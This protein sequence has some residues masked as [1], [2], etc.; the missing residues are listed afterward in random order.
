MS[1]RRPWARSAKRSR[2]RAWS[3]SSACPEIRSCCTTT[4]STGRSG[5]SSSGTRPRPSSWR[6]P[7]RGSPGGSASSTR[8]PAREWRTSSRPARGLYACSPLVSLV[9]AA[10]RNYEG[11][12]VF[13]ETPSLDLARPVTKWA[14]RLDLPTGRRGRSSGRS[15]LAERQAGARFRRD[16]GR[17]RQQAEIPDYRPLA[18]LRGAGDPALVDG[19][20]A[21]RRRRRPVIVVGGGVGL[22]RAEGELVE[23]AERLDA[24]VVTTPSGRGSI[25]ETHRLAFGVVGLYGPSR[26]QAL[27]TRRMPP[28]V[29]TRMEEFQ[30][31]LWKLV[32]EAAKVV[33]VD[34][35]PFEIGRN[36]VADVAIAGDAKLVLAQLA[37]H[38]AERGPRRPILFG[39]RTSSRSG[40]RECAAGDGPLKTKQVVH[41]LNDTFGEDSCSST[42]T[43][44]RT[45]GRTTART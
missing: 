18:G 41:A 37:S 21:P 28:L 8:A 40:R 14:V 3:T 33:Q 6:W 11:M 30:S 9:S 1:L 36:I 27:S 19:R 23:L 17:R 26:A 45:S 35:D 15:A 32:P 13:Q 39:S 38:A 4:S 44:P 25:C 22:A 16:P 12:G 34:I 43:E 20:A 31:G 24:P 7:T 5:R 42:R 10:D 29:G 2:P